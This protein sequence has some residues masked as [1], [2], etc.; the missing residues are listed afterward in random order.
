MDSQGDDPTQ[1][2]MNKQGLTEIPPISS[3]VMVLECRRNVIDTLA[4]PENSLLEQLDISDNK[5]KSIE[6]VNGLKNLK[7][8]DAG[9]NLIQHIPKLDLPELKELYLMSND[10]SRIENMCFPEV[11]KCDFANNDLTVLEGI[12]CPKLEEGYFG[13]N[14][15]TTITSLEHLKSLKVLDLQYNKLDEFDCDLLPE[16]VE[17]LL[18]NNNKNL[19]S[20]KNL[21]RLGKLKLLG[22]KNTKLK[23]VDTHQKTE[24]W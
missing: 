14:S 20:I 13:A 16:N 23:S 8:L 4:F 19:S 2:F 6:P 21:E 7:T 22:I 9:Y 17:V 11:I 5:I 18:L 12:G 10:I 24:I 1:V 15:L 3:Q